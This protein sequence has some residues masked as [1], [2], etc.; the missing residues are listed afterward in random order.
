MTVSS[1]FFNGIDRKSNASEICAIFDGV[2]QDG[3]FSTIGD[4]FVVNAI[5]GD[6]VSIGS[7]KAWFRSSWLKNDATIIKDIDP[8][9]LLLNRIDLIVLEFDSSEPVRANDIKYI[10][11]T[12]AT[13]PVPP[14]LASGPLK[15]QYI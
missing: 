10:K 15:Y 6:Q 13:N 5:G 1:G 12:P 2:I 11:G 9:E 4:V 14:A 7:G 8:A 3:V